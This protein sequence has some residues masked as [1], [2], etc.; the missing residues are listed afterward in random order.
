MFSIIQGT[1]DDLKA[2]VTLAIKLWPEHLPSE[3]EE[4]FQAFLTD[5]KGVVF[6]ALVKGEPVGFS[7]V[8]LRHDYVEGT[9]TSPV[10][11]L[12]GIY[13]NEDRRMKGIGKALVQAGEVWSKSQGCQEFASDC[14]LENTESLLFHLKV[15]F[16]EASR[17]ICFTKQL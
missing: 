14:F 13:V 8:Q 6:L 5:K 7:Q 16:I 15:G 10:G 12:E 4:F 3:L 1:L 2:I 11:Y 17:L 9:S